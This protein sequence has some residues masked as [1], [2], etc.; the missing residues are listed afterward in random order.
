MLP[1]R[2]AAGDLAPID[3]CRKLIET[4]RGIYLDSDLCDAALQLLEGLTPEELGRLGPQ[5]TQDEWL[6]YRSD[7]G[8]AQY[9]RRQRKKG[10]RPPD[11]LTSRLFEAYCALKEAGCR[12]PAAFLA[13]RLGCTSNSVEMR[14]EPR[15]KEPPLTWPHSSWRRRFWESL[16]PSNL[17]ISPLPEEQPFEFLTQVSRF[18][19]MASH[20]SCF[21]SVDVEKVGTTWGWRRQP[22]CAAGIGRAA[23]IPS[24]STAM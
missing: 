20:K 17:A 9:I 14:L 22:G 18:E 11:D 21:F 24:A 8:R 6:H 10:R 15:K 13:R 4:F 7:S 2:H 19:G 16:D 1:L 3:K 23:A 5:A 12:T